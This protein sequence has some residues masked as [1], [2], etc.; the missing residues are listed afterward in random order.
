MPLI[1]PDSEESSDKDPNEVMFRDGKRQIAPYLV[2]LLGGMDTERYT[3][4]E[5]IKILNQGLFSDHVSRAS[6]KMIANHF[7]DWGR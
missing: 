1:F 5:V 6:D 2:A 3:Y 4:D 7:R